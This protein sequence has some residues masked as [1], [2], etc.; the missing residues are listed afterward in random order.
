MHLTRLITFKACEDIGPIQTVSNISTRL[1]IDNYIN[2]E[3]PVIVT[4]GA[5]DWPVVNDPDFGI[6]IISEVITINKYFVNR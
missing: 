4:D 6:D 1:L 3:V 5:L 2:Q